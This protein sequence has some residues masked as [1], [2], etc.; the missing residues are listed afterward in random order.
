MFIKRLLSF[1]IISLL[2]FPMLAQSL[3]YR[4]EDDNSI[5]MGT[6]YYL[7]EKGLFSV[8]PQIGVA[9]EYVLNKETGE[10]V[11]SLD[12]LIETFERE[13]S[14]DKN[15]NLYIKTVKG[16]V[17]TLH[18]LQTNT[19]VKKEST[20]VGD[21]SNSSYYRIY[22]HYLISNEDLQTLMNEGVQKLSFMT[23]AGYF[24]HNYTKETIGA[25]LVKEYE[26]LH[27]KTNFDEGF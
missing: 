11:Y 15:A 3:G 10:E 13:F 20:R 17:I 14:I 8:G 19:E 23:T 9:L 21:R 27:G 7:E 18:H 26:L 5:K 25:I 12:F 22:P 24:T 6:N 16:N 4:E 2:A 1:T